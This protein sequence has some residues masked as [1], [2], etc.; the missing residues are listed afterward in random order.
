MLV[1]ILHWS[2]QNLGIRYEHIFTGKCILKCIAGCFSINRYFQNIYRKMHRMINFVSTLWLQVVN[3]SNITKHYTKMV[4]MGS[5]HIITRSIRKMRFL[6]M[7]Y[8]LT[9]SVT[10]WAKWKNKYCFKYFVSVRAHLRSVFNCR[11][12]H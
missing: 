7:A 4:N 11:E 1:F 3:V 5:T 2:Q 8:L 10:A 6:W 9:V 12:F